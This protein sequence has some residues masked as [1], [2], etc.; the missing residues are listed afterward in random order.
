MNALCFSPCACHIKLTHAV[1]LVFQ[2]LEEIDRLWDGRITVWD[3]PDNQGETALFAAASA[4]DRFV[5][6]PTPRTFRHRALNPYF[7]HRHVAHCVLCCLQ[8]SK[9]ASVLHSTGRHDIR[10]HS[11]PS[12]THVMFVTGIGKRRT[13]SSRSCWQRAPILGQRRTTGALQQ[14]QQ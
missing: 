7:S 14:W 9:H 10:A 11:S 4:Q 12:D 3:T 13:R 6:C 8:F 1:L 2:A 5:H